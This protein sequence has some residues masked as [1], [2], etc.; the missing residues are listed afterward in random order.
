MFSKNDFAGFACPHKEIKFHQA[1][2]CVFDFNLSIAGSTLR[3]ICVHIRGNILKLVNSCD[4]PFIKATQYRDCSRLL[5]EE[6]DDTRKRTAIF[7]PV[8]LAHSIRLSN[9][10]RTTYRFPTLS[11][12]CD[13]LSEAIQTLRQAIGCLPD[14]IDTSP[15]TISLI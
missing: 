13:F 1:F 11:L 6:V 3:S 10:I 9:Y 2:N 15:D 7:D 5:F 14:G 12:Q 4:T 8:F